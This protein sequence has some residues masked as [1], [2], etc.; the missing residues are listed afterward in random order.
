MKLF[1]RI[2]LTKI[3]FFGICAIFGIFLQSTPLII[4]SAALGFLLLFER[5]IQ[6]QI[7]A[8]MSI[9]FVLFI[10]FALVLGS[11][12]DF[13]EKFLWWDDLLHGFYG[14]AFAFLGYLLIQH[15]SYKRGI[16]N[17][18][19]VICLFSLCFSIAFGALWEVYEFTYDTLFDGNMQRT[20][21]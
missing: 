13:Y 6:I 14:A 8:S 11:Y 18:I 15:I 2:Q 20:D 17:D 21:Q 7:P 19:L 10:V 3:T 1:S 12:F 16:S 4:V 5:Y 9:I